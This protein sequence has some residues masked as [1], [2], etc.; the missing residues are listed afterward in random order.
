MTMRTIVSGLTL[1]LFINTTCIAQQSVL[2]LSGQW[3]Y[4]L[5]SLSVG[6]KEGW[7]VKLFQ[8]TLELPGTLDDAGVGKPNDFTVRFEKSAL[9]QLTRKHHYTGAVW[10]SREVDI[11]ETWKNKNIILHLE[12]VIWETQVWVDGKKCGMNE[13]LVAPHEFDLTTFL[14][15]GKHLITIRI[16]NQEKYDVS[17]STRNLAHAYTDGTQIIWNGVIGNICLYARENIFIGNVQVYP[18]VDAG[19]LSAVINVMNPASLKISGEVM[20]QVAGFPVP[21]KHSFTLSGEQKVLTMQ[22]VLGKN[23]KYWDEFDPHLYTLSVNVSAGKGKKKIQDEKNIPFGMRKLGRDKDIL[24]LNNHR[25]FLRGTLECAIFPLTG[26]PPMDIPGWKKI[27]DAARAYGLNHL[28]FHSWCPPE[29]AFQAADE[30]GFYLQIELPL[31]SLTAG[32]DERINNFLKEEA[33][34]II[35]SYGNHPSFCFWSMGNE[36]EG[37]FDWIKKLLTEL[38]QA[39]NRHLY[40]TTTFTFQKEKGLWPEPVDDF[41]VTQY[42]KKGW[43]RG[44]GIFDTES[45]SFNKDYSAAVDSMPVPVISHEIGQYS[46]YPALPEIKKYNGVLV[47]LNFKAIQQDLEQKKML[48]S[49]QAFTVASGKF[50]VALYK[51]EIERALKTPGFSGFQ[52][53]D[54]HDFPGQGTALVG[55]LDAFWESKGLVTPAEFRQFCAAVVPLIRFEKAVYTNTETF[56]A[57]VELANFGQQVLKNTVPVWKITTPEGKLLASGKLQAIDIP[58][59]NGI[60]LGRIRYDLQALHEATALTVEVALEGTSYKNS[61]K[62]WVYPEQLTAPADDVIITRSLNEALVQ[63]SKGKKVLLNPPLNSIQGIEGKFV[64]VFWSP[65]HFPN[66]PGSMGLLCSPTH[67]AL[68]HFP[69]EAHADWQ[70]WYLC[71]NSKPMLLDGLGDVKPV[72]QVIDNFYKNRRLGDL[73]EAKVGNG[74]LMLCSIDL[75]EEALQHPE[76]RQLRYSILKYMNSQEFNPQVGMTEAD[77]KKIIRQD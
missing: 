13:S 74:K 70:W 36:L 8:Q 32:K 22:Y 50:A 49:A 76:V 34:R 52:L 2:K 48:A 55:V 53:L 62:I 35:H 15:P 77:L 54:L 29:A 67:P 10:Y 43:I 37:N 6:E 20:I 3:T 60:S 25:I 68:K 16:D 69:T 21:V 58:I 63:V 4:Q 56:E 19:T 12:R 59:G 42:T 7:N 41:Y 11:A 75:E 39:D 14:T 5:D 57:S 66:Q 30:T 27:F 51:E 45:P 72:V 38:R 24:Q 18:D 73:I 23:F 28:R 44:Q 26:Y 31:W 71:K 61:W 17:H 46:I 64:P 65:V 33:Y 1:L 40:T 9:L 47:P